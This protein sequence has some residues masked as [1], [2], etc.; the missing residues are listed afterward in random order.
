MIEIVHES[1]TRRRL[2]C[3]GV[4]LGAAALLGCGGDE[5][6]DG[7]AGGPADD[8]FPVTIDGAFG[9]TRIARRPERVVAAGFLRDG[10]D[11]L[12]LG[13]TPI[14]MATL[15]SFPAGF[16]P[17]TLAALGSAKPVRLAATERMPFE[18]IAA[19][20]PDLILATDVRALEQHYDKLAGIAPTLAY[21][22]GAEADP[23]QQRARRIGRAL[24]R[25]P[26]AA[27]LIARIERRIGAVR[28]AHPEFAGRTFTIGPV[29][30]GTIYTVTRTSDA[31][32][33]FLGDLGLE[34]SPRV[35]G[36]RGSVAGRAEV[37]PERISLLDADVMM[38]T[39][40]S[41]GDRRTVESSPLFERLGAVR[42]GAYVPLDL[43][44]ALA[45]GYPG[46][47]AIPYALERIVAPLA[48]ALAA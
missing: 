21:T 22:K 4:A 3:N 1:L 19:A 13:I 9:P 24:G 32:A 14:A 25:S 16:S 26:Q 27:E 18:R 17:W 20:R 39:Y 46:L 45:S 37:S 5:D 36:L 8:A 47:L 23:W 15:D 34:L 38:L 6:G 43:T 33:A 29:M 7:A 31:A 10:D 12:A 48:K 35:V 44:V 42:R 41:P 2:L 28:G 11:A 40:G 30:G